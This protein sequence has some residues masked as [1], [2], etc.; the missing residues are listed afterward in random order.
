MCLPGGQSAS[1][2][3][4]KEDPDKKEQRRLAYEILSG[5][6]T[7]EEVAEKEGYDIEHI[8]K[9]VEEYLHAAEKDHTLREKL[10]ID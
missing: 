2:P 1:P 8:K 9:W 6:I 4:P 7:P 3:E 10:D 5:N